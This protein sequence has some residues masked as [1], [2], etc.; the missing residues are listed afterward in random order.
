MSYY[1]RTADAL[2]C[3]LLEAFGAVLIEGPKWCGKTTTAR[4]IARSVIQLQDPDMCAEYQATALS[5]PSLLLNGETPRLIDEWQDIPVLWDAVRA[6]VDLR[7]LPGQFILTGSNAINKSEILHSGVGRIAR[8][9][10]M[11]MSLWESHDSTGLVS[12]R[13]LFDNPDYDINGSTSNLRI[14][15]LIFLA[16]RGGWPASLQTRSKS[17]QL[18]IAKKYVQSL[19]EDDITRVDGKRRD[20]L[21]TKMILKSYARNISTLA[22]KKT[23]IEDILSLSLIHI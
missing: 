12:L 15:D 4:Q 21:T 7:N 8:L 5:K 16:S 20:S 13:E 14:E 6:Q 3:E 2:L 23:L 18:L 17:S 19:C 22:K 9:R 10:M 1:K 11:P